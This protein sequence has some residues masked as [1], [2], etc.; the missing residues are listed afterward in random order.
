[1]YTAREDPVAFCVRERSRRRGRIFTRSRCRRVGQG[2]GTKQPVARG[3]GKQTNPR[4]ANVTGSREP[5][6]LGK[7]REFQTSIVTSL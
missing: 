7:Q 4:R 5:D 1:M 2:R 6:Q 3:R